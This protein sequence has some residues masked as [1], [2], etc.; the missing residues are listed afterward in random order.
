MADLIYVSR[1][2]SVEYEHFLEDGATPRMEG[3]MLEV[4]IPNERRGDVDRNDTLRRELAG[5]LD[6][7]IAAQEGGDG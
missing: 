4:F 5:A 3:T 2:R 7:A 6:T 1:V